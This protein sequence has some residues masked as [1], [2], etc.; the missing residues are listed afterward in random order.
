[1]VTSSEI[2][3]AVVGRDFGGLIARGSGRTGEFSLR[4]GEAAR[5]VEGG[6]V[7][8][9]DDGAGIRDCLTGDGVRGESTFKSELPARRVESA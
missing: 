8:L 9:E 4:I 2:D 5:F 7:G 3:V 6:P 1:M